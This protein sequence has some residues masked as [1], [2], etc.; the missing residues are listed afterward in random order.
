MTDFN[1]AR[2]A[3][4]DNQIRPSD[5]TAYPVIDAMLSVAREDFVPGTL[6]DV[7]YLGEHLPLGEGRVLLDPRVAGKMLD[8]LAIGPSD[9]VLDIGAGLGYST[10][11]IARLCEVVVGV[12]ENPEFAAQAL[13][14]LGDKG[15][16]NSVI[17]EGPLAAGAPEHGPYDVIVLEGAVES[18]PEALTAQLKDGGR[19][20]AIFTTGGAGAMRLGIKSDGRISWRRM[21]DCAAPLLPGFAQPAEFRF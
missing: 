10:A 13:R 19:I 7:A 15:V 21:F 12:E 5:V 2:L 17:H 16:D 8:A 4:V 1:A 9:L 3:M 14:T 20:G 6:R 11:V 18:L